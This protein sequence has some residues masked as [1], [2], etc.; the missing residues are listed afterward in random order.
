MGFSKKAS[1][2]MSY[3]VWKNED[4]FYKNKNYDCT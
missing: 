4:G 2:K 1:I 3:T